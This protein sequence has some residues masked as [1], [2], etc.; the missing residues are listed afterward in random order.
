MSWDYT[1]TVLAGCL[2]ATVVYGWFVRALE[3]T[4]KPML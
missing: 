1:L 2:I 4:R 3:S